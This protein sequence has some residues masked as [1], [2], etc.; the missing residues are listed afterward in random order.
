MG[1]IEQLQY[2]SALKFGSLT[3][4]TF[5][6]FS[7][8]NPMVLY[9]SRNPN[10][11]LLLILAAILSIFQ[12]RIFYTIFPMALLFMSFEKPSKLFWA[13]VVLY[14]ILYVCSAYG[15]SIYLV[16]RGW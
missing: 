6:T 14:F 13:S 9:H 15:F 8:V 4:F 12:F 16:Q 1:L 2:Y 3:N 11:L 5:Q 7:S 10:A